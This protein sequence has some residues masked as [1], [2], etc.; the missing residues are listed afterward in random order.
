MKFKVDENLPVEVVKLL[1]DNRHNA[2][3]VLEQNLGGEP[4]SR[5]AEVCQKEKRALITLDTDFSD[6][7]TYSPDEFYGLIV[8]RLKKQDKLYVLSA[9]SRLINILLREPLQRHLWIVE[10]RRVRISAGEDDPKNQ[11]TSP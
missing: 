8:L 11:I 4:D 2:V 7:R 6:I 3:T 1:E 9:V 5:I 10:E